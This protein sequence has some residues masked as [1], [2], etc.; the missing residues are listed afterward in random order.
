MTTLEALNT[1]LADVDFITLNGADAV[2]IGLAD[3]AKARVSQG[4]MEREFEVRIS[5]RV[6]EGG[7]WLKSATCATRMLGH[8][9]APINVEVA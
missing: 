3:G 9:F 6:P 5:D 7:A 1:T 4:G 2:R 8:A